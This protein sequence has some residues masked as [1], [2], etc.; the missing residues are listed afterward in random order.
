MQALRAENEEI[1]KN[2][3]EGGPSARP[4]NVVGRSYTS[5]TNPRPVEETRDKA[6]THEMDGESCLN[7]SARM[8]VTLDSAYRHPLTN[9]FIEA[10][11]SDKWKG[12]NR[13]G[14][15]DPPTQTTIWMRILPI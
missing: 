4:T 13:D 2:L 1:R 7:R 12:F 15:M 3:V 8:T 14:M 6:P 10:L 11:L 5:P 9:I